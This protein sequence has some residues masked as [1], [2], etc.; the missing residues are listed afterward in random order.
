MGIVSLIREC[1]FDKFRYIKAKKEIFPFVVEYKYK[2]NGS[3]RFLIN[4]TILKELFPKYSSSVLERVFFDL[5]R[6]GYVVKDQLDGE[7][8]IK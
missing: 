6:E 2:C 5:I 4:I 8:C 3:N 7:W 1:V